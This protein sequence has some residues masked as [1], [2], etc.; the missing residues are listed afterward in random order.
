MTL[1]TLTEQCHFFVEIIE[2]AFKQKTLD[3]KRKKK[4][5]GKID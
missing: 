2:N 1:K 5:L 3:E 4:E